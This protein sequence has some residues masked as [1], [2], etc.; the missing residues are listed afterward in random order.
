[1]TI[2]KDTRFADPGE[3][4]TFVNLFEIDEADI[5]QFVVDWKQRAAKDSCKKCRDC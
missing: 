3:P 2:E 4:F 1:M 5:N